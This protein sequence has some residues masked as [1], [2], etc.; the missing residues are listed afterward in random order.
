VSVN[1]ETG[2]GRR[3]VARLDAVRGR[4]RALPGGTL[5][6][7]VAV[8][9]VG[10]V[11]IVFGVILLPLPGPGWLI[12]FAGLGILATEFTWAARLLSGARSFVRAWTQWL[13]RQR[14]WVRLLVG[15]GCLVVVA[16][17]IALGWYLVA[18][19]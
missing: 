12:I 15:L 10:T 4:L 6:W 16:G 5:A 7:R 19:R 17:G 9:T 13:L 11:T 8:T 1:S 18:L 14:L 2:A 3:I